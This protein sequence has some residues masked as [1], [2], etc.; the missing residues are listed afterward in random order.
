M[1]PIIGI[2]SGK[3]LGN[4]QLTRISLIDKYVQAIQLAGGVPLVIPTGLTSSELVSC[5]Q[6]FDGFLLTGGGD[7]AIERFDG[8]PNSRISDVDPDRDRM[9]IE[10]TQYAFEENIPLFGICRGIQVINV[11]MGG[12][13]FTDINS[14]R[15]NS[16]KHDWYPEVARNYEAHSVKI[17]ENSKVHQIIHGDEVNV[18]SLHHQAIQTLGN[19]LSPTAYA[20]DG[21]I[22]AIESPPHLFFLG[23]QWHPEWMLSSPSMV[24]LFK[25]FVSSA[26]T[27]FQRN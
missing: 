15:E 16:I 7:I 13:L 20:P 17:V 21:I 1:P 27:K 22:E 10:I 26:K 4:S 25:Q 14:Q 8:E 3:I 19:H 6:V 23:V 2:T 9:E 18:N 5:R 24:N 12:S 11:T